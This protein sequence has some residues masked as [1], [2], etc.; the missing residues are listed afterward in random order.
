M[1]HDKLLIVFGDESFKLLTCQLSMVWY[2]PSMAVAGN[3]E[4]GF[5]SGQ[6][7]ARS[8]ISA[9]DSRSALAGEHLNGPRHFPKTVSALHCVERY[10]ELLRRGNYSVAGMLL[11]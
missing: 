3:R 6:A 5:D 9:E 11:W 8:W 10:S 4:L 2:W 7:K 1:I